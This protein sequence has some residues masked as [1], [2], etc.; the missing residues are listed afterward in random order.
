MAESFSHRLRQETQLWIRD[1]L[2]SAQQAEAIVAR[3]RY[4]ERGPWYSR[5][6]AIFSLL[7]GALLVG[8]VALIVAH[9][10]AEI[11]RW[12]KLG[13]VV[14]MLLAAHGGGLVLRVRD[15][16]K[17]GEGLFVLGGGLLLVGIG[18]VGQLYNL[19]GRPSDGIL[20]WW[21]L[22]L[23]AAYALPSMALV[24]LAWVGASV[25]FGLLIYDR[26]TWLGRDIAMNSALAAVAVGAAG[27]LAWALGAIHGS[28][29]FRR[30]RQFLEQLGLLVILMALVP[31]GFYGHH[32]GTWRAE[33]S[34]RWPMAVLGL[35]AVA[36]VAI[37]VALFRLPPDRL[38]VRAGLPLTFVVVVLFLFLVAAAF[39]Q[40]APA[41]T[42]RALGWA[43]WA[44]LFAVAL[45]L[46][47]YGA[48]W[49]RTS[50]INWGVVWVGVDAVARY[51]E[52]FGTMLQT[53]ALFFA[54]GLFVLAVGWALELLRRR[55]TPRAAAPPGSV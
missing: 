27:V 24:G 41:G 50:W 55:V 46:I 35:L 13:G 48:R 17:T 22:L 5:P 10:W 40:R 2:V 43:N 29:E 51:L 28:G 16:G 14:A 44:L 23:P 25:W 18:L 1:G 19:A 7:G 12:A 26:T 33:D 3:Y 39:M 32:G 30:A 11:P 47:L 36:M 54:T 45:A 8:G 20:L 4:S 53:S 15:Y 37:V 42:L 38:I 21:A 49:D 52:L 34:A 9:N 31:L 6:I